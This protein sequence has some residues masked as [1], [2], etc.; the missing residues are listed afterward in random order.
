MGYIQGINR[1]QLTILPECLDDYIGEDNYTRIID[2]FVESLELKEMNFLK[3]TPAK[4]G[5]PPYNPRDLL[6]LYIYGYMNRIRSSRRL[7]KETTRNLELIWLINKLHPDF[8]TIADFRKDNKE[9][10]KEVFKRFV[11]LCKGWSLYGK[12][13]ITVDSSKFKAWNSKKKNFNTA[14]LDKKIKDIDQKIDEYLA[15]LDEND[16]KEPKEREITAEEIKKRIEQLKQ[17]QIKYEEY[18]KVIKESGET[19]LSLTD[20]EARSMVNNQ[21]VEVCYSVQTTVE[22]KNKL[23]LDYEVTNDTREQGHLSVMGNRAKEILEVE[24]IEALADKGYYLAVDIKQCVDDKI[25][26]YIPKP[27][28]PNAPTQEEG[29]RTKNF[30]YD[31]ARDLYICPGKAELTLNGTFKKDGKTFKRY[32]NRSA[33]KVC[34]L[35]A[36]CNSATRNGRNIDR[37][38]HQEIL[39]QVEHQT[40]T[41]WEKYRKRQS[42]VEHPFGTIKRGFDAYYLLTKGKSSVGAE[43]G[44]T[45][46]TYNLKRV[47]KILGVKELIT[48]L[49]EV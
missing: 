7:E 33:C 10:I 40:K 35:K 15:E 26:P 38:E 36:R 39:D 13:L 30:Q 9:A 5:R 37:W 8:K 47:I 6:K 42:I 22:E 4:E 48:R 31:Q 34:K 11:L 29:F 1:D 41:N 27:E 25:N 18:K 23:I 46:L 12:E 44:L 16:E 19:Q 45:Y 24:T 49:A 14:K 17:K 43:I 32:N 2:A 3:V 21:K 20:S 28:N